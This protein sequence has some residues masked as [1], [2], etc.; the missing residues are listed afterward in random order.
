MTTHWILV[1][2]GRWHAWHTGGQKSV[3]GVLNVQDLK[4]HP[5]S[6][7]E[8]E[9]APVNRTAVCRVC[10]KALGLP[11]LNGPKGVQAAWFGFLKRHLERKFVRAS[12]RDLITLAGLLAEVGKPDEPEAQEIFR[13][14]Q[15]LLLTPHRVSVGGGRMVTI[16]AIRDALGALQAVPDAL[17]KISAA[18]STWRRITQR[19]DLDKFK[20]AQVIAV[21]LQLPDVEAYV[22]HL[23]ARGLEHLAA[24]SHPNTL[25]RAKKD[26]GL[27]GTFSGSPD[28]WQS[29]QSQ[30]HIVEE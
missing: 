8:R 7:I 24:V 11:R 13:Q 15:T 5:P 29:T 27:R 21:M 1:H 25:E 19:G 2:T 23:K 22:R 9:L 3:C 20:P 17:R 6:A 30:L 10:A 18:L 16:T 28:F 12:D 4:E 14:M 26:P